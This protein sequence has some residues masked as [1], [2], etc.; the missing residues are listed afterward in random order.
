MHHLHHKYAV[1]VTMCHEL[2]D[3]PIQAAFY[4]ILL[5]FEVLN[6]WCYNHSL[7]QGYTNNAIGC[8]KCHEHFNG[9]ILPTYAI[10]ILSLI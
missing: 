9:P 5:E 10:L 8:A 1:G 7:H 4:F 3:G 2:F 6:Y